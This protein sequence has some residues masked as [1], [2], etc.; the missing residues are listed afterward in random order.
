MCVVREREREGERESER[1]AERQGTPVIP[2][3]NLPGS[4]VSSNSSEGGRDREDAVNNMTA[5]HPNSSK[6]QT[7]TSPL[8]D[9]SLYQNHRPSQEENTGVQAC[10]SAVP[11]QAW[12]PDIHI[13]LH[14]TEVHKDWAS[15][16]GWTFGSTLLHSLHICLLD[17]AG[18]RITAQDTRSQTVIGPVPLS[19]FPDYFYL[20]SCFSLPLYCSNVKRHNSLSQ[21]TVGALDG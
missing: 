18:S 6:G 4:S 9:V 15:P 14:I 2:C 16:G 20:S 13:T 17:H 8:K 5:L 10:L 7:R 21:G 19:P 11:L 1:Q 3:D 12:R